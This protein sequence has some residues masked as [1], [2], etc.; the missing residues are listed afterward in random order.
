[1]T[2]F[3]DA[4]KVG[5]LSGLATEIGWSAQAGQ[6]QDDAESTSLFVRLLIAGAVVF[7]GLYVAGH[8]FKLKVPTITLSTK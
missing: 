3:W 7:G 1:M 5:G 6:T 2:N 8:I 4:F